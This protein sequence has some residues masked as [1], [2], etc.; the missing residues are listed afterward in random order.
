[1][2]NFIYIIL[3]TIALVSCNTTAK[4]RYENNESAIVENSPKGI[5]IFT[6]EQIKVAG[7]EI[8]KLREIAIPQEIPCTG[9]VEASPQN[10]AKVSIPSAAYIDKIFVQHGSYVKKGE[11]V[12]TIR[13]S[14]FIDLQSNYLKLKNELEYKKEEYLRQKNLFA[15]NAV[16]KKKFKQVKLDYNSTLIDEKKFEQKLILI[17]IDPLGL[18]PEKISSTIKLR[19]P[20]SGYIDEIYVTVS[21]Y[22]EPKDVL[23]EM[24]NNDDFNIM[25]NVYGKYDNSINIGDKVKFKPHGKSGESHI[26]KVFSVGRIIEEDTKTFR[27]H[28]HPENKNSTLTAGAFVNAKIFI[29]NKIVSA[30]PI[31]AVVT[32]ENDSYVFV[33]NSNNSFKLIE[34]VGGKKNRRFVE[35]LKPETLKGH[36]IVVTGANYLLSKYR[37]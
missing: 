31:N 1:M 35:I 37:E 12:L 34:V 33:K 8:G 13:H 20:I 30:L 3:T 4:E 25:L 27:V 6:P 19:A 36:E 28:A 23:F 32:I 11:T 21:Q 10:I 17:G 14:E 18:T 24:V 9:I 29:N 15:E 26:A 22:L 2:K 16:S 7:I 5:V